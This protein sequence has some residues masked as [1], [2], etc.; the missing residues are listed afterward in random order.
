MSSLRIAGR[1]PFSPSYSRQDTVVS[2]LL[3]STAVIS[4]VKGVSMVGN[5]ETARAG[6]VMSLILQ[7]KVT[8]KPDVTLVIRV[9]SWSLDVSK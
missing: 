1:L 4:W 9:L 8:T 3:C 6:G 5:T 7:V 2:V